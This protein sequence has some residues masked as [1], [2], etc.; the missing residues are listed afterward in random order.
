MSLIGRLSGYES[1]DIG[2]GET[3]SDP[4]F[5]GGSA[6]FG[7]IFPAGYTGGATLTIKVGAER[8]SLALLKDGGSDVT[9]DSVADTAVNLPEIAGLFRWMSIVPASAPSRDESVVLVNKG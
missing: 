9:V 4:V 6:G 8:D 1:I 3:E 7:L 2:S 5:I